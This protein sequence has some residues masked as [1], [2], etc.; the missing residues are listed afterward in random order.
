[1]TEYTFRMATAQDA[2]AI[3]AIY[4][5]YILQT[6]IT[7]EYEVPTLEAFTERVRHISHDY[8]YL[9]CEQAGKIIGYGYA[10]AY[11]ER[12]AYQWDADLS[13]YFAPEATGHG[14]GRQMLLKLVEILK[15]QGVRHV[16]SCV[17][18][19][20]KPSERMHAALGF[21]TVGRFLQAGYKCGAWHDVTWFEKTIAPCDAHPAPF[22][23]IRTLPA[24][25]IEV[26]L[27]NRVE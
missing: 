11:H 10:S 1:M 21:R 12:A 18:H 20:N 26:I 22:R 8:P 14:L 3:L 15:L 9:V 13:I 27:G 7:F 5:P 19:P 16:Y 2:A 17:T 23:S 6:P 24:V 25:S 4:A